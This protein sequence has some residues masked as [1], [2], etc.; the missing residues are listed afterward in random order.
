MGWKYG[1]VLFSMFLLA[2]ACQDVR[3]KSVGLWVYIIFGIAAAVMLITRAGSI[4][5]WDR[6]W[7]IFIGLVLLVLGK[8]TEGAI[9]SGD[10]W[11]FAIA[12]CILGFKDSLRLLASGL[13]LC[14]L[15][16]LVI[17]LRGRWIGKN[18]GKETVPFLPFLVPVWIWMLLE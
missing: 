13:L 4:P 7:G 6:L 10:G 11:F 17:Y 8:V 5:G 12:G 9:G 3:K 18:T 1:Q 2:A 15:F 16:S 14:G